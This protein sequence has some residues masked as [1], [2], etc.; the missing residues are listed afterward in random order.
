MDPCSFNIEV[1]AGRL[2]RHQRV[3][4]ATTM[5][6]FID[7]QVMGLHVRLAQNH[8]ALVDGLK[9]YAEDLPYEGNGFKIHNHRNEEDKSEEF[10]V[11]SATK[12]DI[13]V[14]FYGHGVDSVALISI[15]GRFS[16]CMIGLCGNC[17]GIPN[18]LKTRDG[19]DVS[20]HSDMFKEISESY[21]V[22]ESY[23]HVEDAFGKWPPHSGRRRKGG[24]KGGNG[25]P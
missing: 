11:F 21:H 2:L 24:K 1:K 18:D 6:R 7:I 5:P 20:S 10:V 9:I 22:D 13:H 25:K 23:E 19:L 15:P 16:G 4:Y 12:C 17:D 14:G 8:K 3:Q